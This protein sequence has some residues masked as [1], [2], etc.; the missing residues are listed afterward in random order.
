M[1]VYD[2]D[3]TRTFILYNNCSVISPSN[4]VVKLLYVTI[5]PIRPMEIV[6]LLFDPEKANNF[7]YCFVMK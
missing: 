3:F 2:V 7:I 6:A 4:G 1:S 5:I